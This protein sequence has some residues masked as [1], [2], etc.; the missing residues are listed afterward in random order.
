MA[1]KKQ[2]TP[3]QIDQQRE[4]AALKARIAQ[5]EGRPLKRQEDR[6][7]TWYLTKQREQLKE[8]LLTNLPKGIF[9]DLAQRQH[10]TIDDM[11]ERFGIPTDGPT[12]NLYIV[13][14][15]L[16][17]WIS[18]HGSKITDDEYAGREELLNS[19]LR[20]EIGKL[21]LQQES[22]EIEISR[23]K[24]SLVDRVIVRERLQWL[25]GQLQAFGKR[26]ARVG[27]P[28]AQQ[29]LNEFLISLSDEMNSGALRL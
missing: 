25:A 3:E 16:Y 9:C 26:L 20:E 19:K 14:R 13:V 5:L 21:R 7:L 10:K 6:D 27:G 29:S 24:D 22:L 28:E 8:E 1:K 18:E 12:V 4:V 11:A 2:Q 17:D 15:F 23:R